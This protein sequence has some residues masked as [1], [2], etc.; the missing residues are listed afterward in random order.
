MAIGAHPTRFCWTGSDRMT[1][2]TGS[3]LSSLPGRAR[4]RQSSDAIN[5]KRSVNEAINNG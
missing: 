1:L 3:V 4:L 5:N 2:F